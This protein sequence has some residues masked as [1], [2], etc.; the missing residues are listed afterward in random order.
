M[1]D[2]RL[3]ILWNSNSA[4]TNS[5]Y[6]RETEFLLKR[7]KQDGWNVAINAFAGVNGGIANI[8]GITHYPTLMD[9]FGSDG[10]VFHARHFGA[11]VVIT[12]Q[13]IWPLQP[14]HLQMSQQDNRPVVMY[15]PIDQEPVPP[16][17]LEKLRFA[18]KIITFSKFGQQ[19]LEKAGFSS[20]MIYEGVD[21]KIFKP[22]DKA[23]CRKFFNLPQDKFIFGMIGANKDNPPRKGWQEALDAFKLFHDKHPDSL[24]FYAT[25]QNL[26]SG[27]PIRQY[28][29]ELGLDAEVLSIDEYLSIIGDKDLI[30]KMLNSFDVLLHPSTTEGFGLVIIEAQS[31]GIPVIVNNCQSMPELVI[32]GVTG[33]IS[34][35]GRKH[36][37]P[38]GGYWYFA[39]TQDL[40]EK[41]EKLY[42][43]DRIKMGQEAR[44]NVLEKF[45]IDKI[46]KNDWIPYLQELQEDILGKPVD[47]NSQKT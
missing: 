39:D 41:M 30:V 40:Y 4:H 35:L 29:H 10:L 9:A 28:A 22:M 18:N 8:D 46:V 12:F 17:V 14:Q 20:K 45:D 6:G 16:S 34:K 38:A 25:N 27:F 23:E 42:I 36:F 13:D 3:K 47:I 15:V 7:F 31:C 2:R 24:Y 1:K 26:P 33:E 11:N 21:T 37:S 44:K 43:A 19:A 32:E 5:G